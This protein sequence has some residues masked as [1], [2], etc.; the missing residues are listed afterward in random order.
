MKVLI[1]KTSSLGDIIHTLPAITDA[2]KNIPDL[3]IDWVVEEA[4]A[5]VPAWHPA[6]RKIIPVA[7]RRWRKQPLKAWQSGEWQDFIK[8]LK[9]EKYDKV[10]DAQGLIKSAFLTYFA[11]GLRC[12]LNKQSAWEPLASFFYQQ[13]VAV[14]PEQHAITRMRQLLAQCLDYSVP[15]EI[16]D[17][18][19]DLNR[20]KTITASNLAIEN[21]MQNTIVFLH[22]TTWPTKHWPELYWQALAKH[23]TD[24]GYKVQLP[25]GN[26]TEY[27]RAQRI[28]QVSEK[29]EVLP[30]LT[31]AEINHVLINAKAA[32][33]VD[34][35]LGHLAAALHVPTVSLYG[36]TDPAL[37][38]ALGENQ[39]HLSVQFSC[40]PCQQ[41]ICSYHA[42][43][44]PAKKFEPAC[45]ATITPEKVL[46][47]LDEL[48]LKNLK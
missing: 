1:I 40:A 14:N 2:Y 46:Q 41:T 31:L 6:V 12:G 35:G 17:Y 34:T 3:T 7:L 16:L 19:I 47:Q 42:K 30:K 21:T 43:N 5:E 48:L 4:F 22:G 33:A 26:Q 44:N 27:E 32:I 36:P 23:I 25:W 18:G 8:Q 39:I 28:A 20:I 15:T 37:T 29:I 24:N 13:D 45:F 11:E 9:A 10:I 38:G